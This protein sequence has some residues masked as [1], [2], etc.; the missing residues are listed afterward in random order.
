MSAGIAMLTLHVAL[1]WLRRTRQ[2]PSLRATW[3]SVALIG[4]VL[5]TG[6]CSSMIVAMA[7]AGLDYPLGFRIWMALAIWFGAIVGGIGIA[8]AMTR[9]Q[10]WWWLLASGLGFGIV[11]WLV[12][13]GWV[14]AAGLQ[15]GP[16]WTP[17][18]LVAAASVLWIGCGAGLCAA[19]APQMKTRRRRTIWL[20][21]AAA[22]IAVSIIAGQ[23]V[24]MAAGGL[25]D[26]VS[27][28]YSDE[29]PASILGL[30]CGI[31]TPLALGAMATDLAVRRDQERRRRRSKA[32][33]PRSFA[34]SQFPDPGP[35]SRFAR[36]P[37]SER[38]ETH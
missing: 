29:L 10:R 23:E 3:S 25:T 15:P 35:D 11:A 31:L 5:G 37:P 17:E 1:E 8:A 4:A 16:D 18:L 38:Q 9:A 33:A 28:I 13:M 7:S 22:I 26:Q 34:V 14:A 24:M 21:G 2:A 20:V 12:Q 27:S 19:F 30:A 32:L 36:H 6:L